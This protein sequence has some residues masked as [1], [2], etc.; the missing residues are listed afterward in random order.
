MTAEPSV[1]GADSSLTHGT[2]T[3]P[4]RDGRVLLIEKK[5]GIG[6]GLYNGPGGKVEPGETPREA[7]RREV[8][9]EIDTDVPAISK[10]GEIEFVFGTDHYMTVHVYR[11][12]GVTGSPAETPEAR[13]VWMDVDDVA[14]EEM[15]EDDR[16]W[17]PLLFDDR[18]FRGWFRFDGDGTVL[19]G[20]Y[21]V[22]DVPVFATNPDET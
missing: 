8:R 9:E 14:Y 5:R 16:Y 4:V 7:A 17:L 11:S 13:P 20:R 1:A 2:I 10:R 3:F 21:V 12:P 15:W 22:P 18:T 19:R 6:A